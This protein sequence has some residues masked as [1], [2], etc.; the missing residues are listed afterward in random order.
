MLELKDIIQS[1]NQIFQEFREICVSQENVTPSQLIARLQQVSARYTALVKI[2]QT[3]KQDSSQSTDDVGR[4]SSAISSSYDD[5][6]EAPSRHASIVAQS[7]RP[8][9]L[10]VV[11]IPSPDH[12][13]RDYAA[14]IAHQAQGREHAISRFL[15][16]SGSYEEMLRVLPNRMSSR[17]FSQ[18][19]TLDLSYTCSNQE[20][21]FA[22]RLHRATIELAYW[23]ACD[24]SRD[25]L[26][27]DQMFHI[28]CQ[29]VS[30]MKKVQEILYTTLKK[31][32]DE[33]LSDRHFPLSHIGGAGTH[34]PRQE[35]GGG[36][37]NPRPDLSEWN[38]RLPQA[39]TLAIEPLPED[40]YD[41]RTAMLDIVATDPTYRGEWLDAHDVEGYLAEKGI[42]IDPHSLFANAEFSTSEVIESEIT[43]IG[44][45]PSIPVS[46]STSGTNSG[47]SSVGTSSTPVHYL[48]SAIHN[49][50]RSGFQHDGSFDNPHSNISTPCYPDATNS[51]SMNQ[52]PSQLTQPC[53]SN[54]GTPAMSH[55]HRGADI[56]ISSSYNY[57]PPPTPFVSMQLMIRK[58]TIDVSKLTTSKL[59]ML[60]FYN[61]NM[62]MVKKVLAKSGICLGRGPGYRRHNV[63]IALREC[64]VHDL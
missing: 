17:P 34:Y 32:V 64:I 2:T 5:M 3:L 33:P 45:V 16:G 8:G 55:L 12:V 44:C 21:T 36:P 28:W 18:S 35:I 10:P 42:T 51:S 7:A 23:L 38:M 9:S 47:S 52:Q 40:C 6:S 57:M 31:G 30:S 54:C 48:D 22:R 58:V 49:V 46:S 56:P 13:G 63:D 43:H 25:P 60:I 59:S 27:F 50:S 41:S 61:M 15:G 39:P 53:M 4:R 37:W 62:L 11:D 19:M 26:R 20:T 24:P 1:M 14:Y 29:W